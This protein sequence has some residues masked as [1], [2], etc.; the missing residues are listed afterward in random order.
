MGLSHF[1]TFRCTQDPRVWPFW[2]QVIS[3]GCAYW[4]RGWR[5]RWCLPPGQKAGLLLALRQIFPKPRVL[6]SQPP[7][8]QGSIWASFSS[9]GLGGQGNKRSHCS[10]WCEQENCCLWPRSLMSSNSICEMNW[11]TCSF[12]SR[13]RIKLQWQFSNDSLKPKLNCFHFLLK[14]FLVYKEK[15]LVNVSLRAV[16]SEILKFIHI[17]AAG[18]RWAEALRA[19]AEQKETVCAPDM[20]FCFLILQA[21]LCPQLNWISATLLLYTFYSKVQ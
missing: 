13:V 2:I 11:L 9:T 4:E 6:L 8:E 16:R 1:Y 21:A 18:V 17:A 20:S 7:H 3:Q 15:D 10:L 12:V 19:A 14:H 5:L